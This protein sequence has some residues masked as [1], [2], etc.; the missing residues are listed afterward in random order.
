MAVGKT[1]Y[2]NQ[3]PG[4]W[5]SSSG[6]IVPASCDANGNLL[7]NVAAG[8]GAGGTSSVDGTAFT[9]G[10]SSGTP[11]M[12]EDPISGN[13][14]I[15]QMAPGT[16]NLQV[17]ASVTVSPTQS[18]TVSAAGP[19]TIGTGSTTV[20]TASASTKRL[21]LQNTGTTVIY[22]LFGAGSASSSN[23][24]LILPAGGTTK[25]G[26]SPIYSD[27]MWQGAVS[28]ASSAAGGSLNVAVFT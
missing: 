16:R 9:A 21:S 20:V 11:I 25:D 5:Q 23:Y 13:L 14:L 6:L 8:G 24:H 18:S 15:A 22:V 7:V 3:I 17:A 27:I 28:V 2:P 10:S 4:W 1:P 26:S 19:T 12:A